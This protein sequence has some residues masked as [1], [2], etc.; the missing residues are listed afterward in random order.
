MIELIGIPARRG[1]VV[2][3]LRETELSPS[4]AATFA[5]LAARRAGV[6]LRTG[7]TS[8]A[9]ARTAR[10]LD[11]TM[12]VVSV[13]PNWWAP[14]G[15]SARKASWLIAHTGCAVVSVSPTLATLPRRCVAAIDF[16][17]AS[18]RA[19]QMALLLLDDCA[20]LTLVHVRPARDLSSAQHTVRGAMT[21][22]AIAVRFKRLQSELLE[23]APAGTV[24]ETQ[25]ESGEIVDQ[26]LSVAREV[27]SDLITV[28]VHSPR[29]SNRIVD[30][31]TAAGLLRRAPCSV[32]ASPVS[33]VA[34]VFHSDAGDRNWATAPELLDWTTPG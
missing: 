34:R 3:A 23:H 11:A 21:T 4:A 7:Q 9:S 17:A 25:T 24:I 31:G 22:D 29:A 8:T 30:F 27:G 15:M 13:L 33:R 14:L 20:A 1:P 28:G 2:L 18:I 26:V 6:D 16:S 12:L 32:L 5:A 10:E 19:A